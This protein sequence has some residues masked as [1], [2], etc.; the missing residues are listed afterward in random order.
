MRNPTSPARSGRRRPLPTALAVVLCALPVGALGE[1]EPVAATPCSEP[2]AGWCVAHRFPGDVPQGELGFRFGEPLDA[3]GDGRAD[4]AAGSR[5]KL[6][7]TFQSGSAT[8]WSGTSGRPIR[9]WDG[10]R[11]DGLFGHWVALMPDVSG[12]GLA[13]VVIAAPHA[14][15]GGRMRGI[16]VARSPRTGEPLWKREE[17]ESENL[18]WDLALAGDHDGDGHVDLF[19][20]APGAESGRVYLVSGKT[21][22]LLRTYTPP[23]HAGSFGWYVA[24]LGD[25][26][27]DRQPD[28]AVGAPYARDAGGRAIGRAW[29][30]SSADGKALHQWKRTDHRGAFGSVLA[31]VSDLDGDGKDDL[32]VTAPATE[33]QKRTLPGEVWIYSGATGNQL[34]HWTGRQPGELFGRM[35]IGGGDVD[36]DGTDDVAIGAPWHR[37]GAADRVGRVE[38]RSGR[39]GAVLAELFGDEAD[40]WFGWHVR[41]APDPEGRGRPALLIGSLRHPVGGHPRVGVIDLYVY[42]ADRAGAHGTT[43]RGAR[44]SDIK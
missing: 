10:E 16:L 15:V 18:G 3:D 38:I 33:D 40:C 5:F 12:D 31:A 28:L 1:P 35:V 23:P 20:G 13:D 27:G 8:I 39:D 6:Q 21:G 14:P 22:S 42:R 7:G 9:S 26:D 30:L 24:R 44:R 25:L 43:S 29:I 19:V 34:R 11:F 17:T 2:G 32:A 41:R 37:R 4:V 36:G